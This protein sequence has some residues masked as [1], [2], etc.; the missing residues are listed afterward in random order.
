[1]PKKTEEEAVKE[2]ALINGEY[3][4]YLVDE[5]GNRRTQAEAIRVVTKD[6]LAIQDKAKIVLAEMLN[7]IYDEEYYNTWGYDSFME[8][9][10][11][12]L[13]FEYRQAMYLVKIWDVFVNKRGIPVNV[14]RKST[15]SKLKEIIKTSD[16][17][18]DGTDD[19]VVDTGEIKQLIEDSSKMTVEQVSYKSKELVHEAKGSVEVIER[20]HRV[21]LTLYEE[22]YENFK[23][24]LEC[25]STISTSDKPG[26]NL[27]LISTSYIASHI[28]ND[29]AQELKRIAKELEK[30]TGAKIMVALD[31]EVV[32]VHPDLSE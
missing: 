24:A 29:P 2:L 17:K 26:A 16:L 15:W 20:T 27:D 23:K 3:G 22:Q 30:V 31:D 10:K 11:K 18:E 21:T 1:M 4:A 6:L 25:A 8:Y 9:V 7:K 28:P 19:F 14:L 12:E 32:H 13:D 5:K